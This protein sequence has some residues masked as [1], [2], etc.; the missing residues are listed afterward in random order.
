MREL[1][2][3]SPPKPA[4]IQSFRTHARPSDEVYDAGDAD[5]DDQMLDVDQSYALPSI[6]NDN[7]Q[8]WTND[9]AFSPKRRKLDES[10]AI[11]SPA[12]PTFKYPGAPASESTR[13]TPHFT[14]SHQ[15]SGQASTSSGGPQTQR[16][17]FV[18][19]STEPQEPREPLPETFSPHKRGQ[20]FVPG[21]MAATMQQW[22][23]ETGQAAVQSRKGQGYL[24]G[25]DY[26][27]R[28]KIGSINGD[29]P[30]TAHATLPTG[31]AIHLI[32]TANHSPRT[33]QTQEVTEGCVVGIRAPTWEMEVDRRWWTIG[34]DW[35]VIS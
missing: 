15:Q 23:I 10:N 14:P 30:F 11:P 29:E 8:Q 32:L 17:A 21:G 1:R 16:P 13:A 3:P 5:E 31:D 35:K 24:K 12:R 33:A 9:V 26:V 22:V 28:A 7:E 2:L 34:V 19:P 27:M 6:E 18:R 20:K 4:A 25:E